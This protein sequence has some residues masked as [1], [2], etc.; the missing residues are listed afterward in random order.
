MTQ[1]HVETRD[2]HERL[3]ALPST[4][5]ALEGSVSLEV[6]ISFLR[7][8][9]IIQERLEF[10]ASHSSHEAVRAVWRDEMRK[11][12]LLE[13]DIAHFSAQ[14]TEVEPATLQA[15]LI[16]QQIRIAVE[17]DPAELLGYLY[18]LERS[19]LDGLA[20]SPALQRR[21]NLTGGGLS[22]VGAHG[23]DTQAHFARFIERLEAA[24]RE[25]SVRASAMAGAQKAFKSLEDLLFLLQHSAFEGSAPLAMILNPD[26]GTHP[27]SDDLREIEAALRAG[28]ASWQQFPYLEAR[29]GERGRRFTRSD[30]AWLAML[31]HRERSHVQRDILWL[32]RVLAARGMPRWVL[33]QHLSTLHRLLSSAIP[34]RRA[35]YAHLDLAA[36]MLG[37]ARTSVIADD[38]FS[39]LAA[40]FNA[41]VGP[42]LSASLPDAGA[43]LVAAVAD[44]LG[45]VPRSVESVESWMAAPDRFPPIWVAAVSATI[46]DARAS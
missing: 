12:A 2:L 20:Q 23:D 43:I 39:P 36:Q 38:R 33:E 44:E 13:Q 40:A 45:G 34:E 10:V 28:E 6:Y 17:Q 8:M 41:R 37:Q 29:Y 22:Y 24:V 1:L 16:A 9:Q 7:A 35:H 18:V 15:E 14:T 4:R 5:T 46:A 26:A 32:G 25:E 42:T 31:S 21:F 3:G 30:S 19:A 27:I 11:A